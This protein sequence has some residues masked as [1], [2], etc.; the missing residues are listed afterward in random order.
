MTSLRQSAWLMSQGVA[1]NHGDEEN[2][3]PHKRGVGSGWLCTFVL[4]SFLMES[5]IMAIVRK[6]QSKIMSMLILGD[7]LEAWVNQADRCASTWWHFRCG[8]QAKGWG[9][10]RSHQIG[11]GIP[12]VKP[13]RWAHPLPDSCACC[14]L[15]CRAM[16]L[17][18]NRPSV[19][20]VRLVESSWIIW[21]PQ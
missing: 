8:E 13:H 9:L 2:I 17:K 5:L 14:P 12:D 19:K 3:V 18:S 1:T 10:A 21:I 11:I 15:R 7:D 6:M 20:P 4:D 16:H